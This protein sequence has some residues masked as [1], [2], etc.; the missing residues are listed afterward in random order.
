MVEP[1]L[2]LPVVDRKRAW[3]VVESKRGYLVVV[4]PISPELDE[5]SIFRIISFFTAQE[6][7][8]NISYIVSE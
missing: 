1:P 6:V 7:F 8:N 5:S 4:V 2:G 3:P